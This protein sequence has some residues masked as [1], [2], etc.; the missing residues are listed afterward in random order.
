MPLIWRGRRCPAPRRILLGPA[1]G[2]AETRDDLVEDEGHAE[3]PRHLANA[4]E[5]RPVRYDQPLER[6][7]DDGGQAL[8]MR[9]DD[10]FCLREV[11]EGGDEHLFADGVRDAT[12]GPGGGGRGDPRP[13][14]S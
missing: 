4:G 7:H 8:V 9:G 1:I 13:H 10:R 6:L 11:V 12:A 5:K 14:G 3:P 2:E